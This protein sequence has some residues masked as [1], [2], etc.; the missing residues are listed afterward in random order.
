[1]RLIAGELTV[2]ST[3]GQGSRLEIT[4][5]RNGDMAHEF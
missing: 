4:V 2:E 1:V 5:P 3:P